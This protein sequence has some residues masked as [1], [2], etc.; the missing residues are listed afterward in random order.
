MIFPPIILFLL[1][2]FFILFGVYLLKEIKEKQKKYIWVGEGK[3]FR[4]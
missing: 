2:I 4:E 3:E 1:G